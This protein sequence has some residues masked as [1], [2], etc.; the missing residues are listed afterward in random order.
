MPANGLGVNHY[1]FVALDSMVE[2]FCEG[3]MCLRTSIISTRSKT[4]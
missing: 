4:H 2:K 1:D 3:L